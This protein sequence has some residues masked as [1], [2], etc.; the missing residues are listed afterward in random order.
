[1]SATIPYTILVFQR[2]NVYFCVLRFIQRSYLLKPKFL[3]FVTTLF[4]APFEQAYRGTPRQLQAS[5][6]WRL[7]NIEY[8]PRAGREQFGSFLNKKLRESK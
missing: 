7:K 8:M 4:L 1:M 3:K 6:L 5:F 2:Y